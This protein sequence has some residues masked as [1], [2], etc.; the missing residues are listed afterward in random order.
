MYFKIP[1]I[2]NPACKFIEK[3]L[4]NVI[5][6]YYPHADLKPDF[7]NNFTILELTSHKE[8]LPVGLS[9][10]IVYLFQCGACSATYIGHSKK[11]LLTRA[12][13]HFGRSS[14][15][16]SLLVRPPQSSIRDHLEMCGSGGSLENFKVLAS[17]N[18]QVLL[19]ILESLEIHFR[20]PALNI[21]GSSFP[22]RMV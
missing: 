12:H 17:F 10:G 14:R 20:K 15:T 7:K 5:S 16:D 4:K 3:E 8:K 2:S 11:C 6:K 1:F 19:K 13:E 18:N 21:D 22:L 9:S